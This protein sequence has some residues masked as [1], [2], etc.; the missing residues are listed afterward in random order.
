MHAPSNARRTVSD[1]RIRSVI[2]CDALRSGDTHV[3]QYY[4][5]LMAMLVGLYAHHVFGFYPGVEFGGGE[6]TQLNC[7]FL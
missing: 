2:A 6:I 1:S 5:P 7:C 3:V 4:F